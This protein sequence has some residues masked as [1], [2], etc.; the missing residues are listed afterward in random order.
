MYANILV[1][2][3]GSEGSLHALEA[4]VNLATGSEP[5]DITVLQ[6]TGI[7]DFDNSTFETAVRMAGLEPVDET[8]IE[9]LR[10]SYAIAHNDQMKQRVAEY[11]E[12]LPDNINMHIIVRRGSA[13]D[14]ICQYA[15]DND[16]DCIIMGRRGVS[17]IRAALGSV[18]T[19]VLRGT[20]LPV[21]VVK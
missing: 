13:R 18:S 3:D 12:S 6:V 5:V 2:F 10:Q 8:Q 7:S 20:D 15:K 21:L 4:A 17:G 1:P 14:V 16:I 9:A 11:F 19:A